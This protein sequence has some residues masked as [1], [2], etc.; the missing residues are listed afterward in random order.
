MHL[1]CSGTGSP[2][3]VLVAGTGNAGDIW[4]YA[5]TAGD[6]ANPQVESDGAVFQTTARSTRACAYD[7]PGTE[8]MD[9]SPGRSSSVAQPT[10]TAGDAAD[11]H[12]LLTAAGVPGPHVLVAHSLGA[13]MATTYART[14]PDDVAGLVLID[15]ASQYMAEAM[16]P[17]AWGQYVEAALSRA[18]SG[19]ESATVLRAWATSSAPW[20]WPW[21]DGSRAS[22]ARRIAGIWWGAPRASPGGASWRSRMWG[23][24]AT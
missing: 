21:S 3:V 14:H 11:I 20:P 1:E 7:R 8:R 2:T 12:T 9:G 16:G 23:A 24:R 19:G 4:R 22:L 18:G 10:T 6:P 13:L 17:D 15:P 5:G